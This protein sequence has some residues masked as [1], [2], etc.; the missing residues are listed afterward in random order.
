MAWKGLHLSRPAKLS[1]AD[2]QLVAAQEDGDA[3]VA[4][5]DLAYLVLDAAHA[6]ISTSLLSALME[7]GVAVLVTDA[8]HHPCGLMLPFHRH[9]RQA[10]VAALQVEAGAPLKKRLWQTIVR[11]KIGNQAA[12][13]EGC[14]REGCA[15]LREMAR[16]VGSGD[17]DNIEARAAREYWGKLFPAFVRDDAKDRRNQLLNYGYA[18]LRAGVGRALAAS[19]FLP[20]LGLHHASATNAFNLADDLLEP[21]RPFVDRMAFAMAEN[22][23]ARA[24]D[25]T[26]EDRRK[27]AGALLE[28]ARIGAEKVTLLVAAEKAA[29]SLARALE[30]NLA[31]ALELPVLEK[32]A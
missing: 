26:V 19:G 29:A 5:E 18:V 4:I 9:H 25:L 12:L 17:P 27:L 15:P 1:V 11:G 13:L 23:A 28:A 31:E 30:A 7:G 3:R 16:L 32:A 10:A 6:Q 24:P 20:A 21:F 8:R 2:G 14:G 22:G